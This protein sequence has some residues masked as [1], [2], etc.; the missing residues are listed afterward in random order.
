MSDNWIIIIPESPDFVPTSAAQQRAI[1]LFEILAPT[2]HEVSASTSD[3]VQFMHC[4]TNWE[5]VVCPTCK[6]EIATVW[7][8]DRMNDEAKRGYPLDQLEVPCCGARHNLH[9]LK[10]EWPMGFARFSIEAMNPG[11]RD[12]TKEHV[13]AFESILGC[14][15]RTIWRHL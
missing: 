7:W 12:L 2:A 3:T 11:I 9:E 10:Y 4:G 8:Q 13:A 1:A 15:I 14:P 6:N 5:R